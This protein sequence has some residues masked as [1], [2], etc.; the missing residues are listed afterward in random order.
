ME[1]SGALSKITEVLTTSL[2]EG[3]TSLF[4]PE[5]WFG[6]YFVGFLLGIVLSKGSM[7]RYETVSGMFRFF[8]MTFMRV[9]M[10]LFLFGMPMVFLAAN[11]G[12]IVE[13][14][15]PYFKPIALSLG[16]F[17]FGSSMAIGGYCPG[18]GL[19]SLGRGALDVLVW[20]VGLVVGNIFF[21]EVIYGS[22]FHKL[23]E[24]VSL[25]NPTWSKIFGI[26][27]ITSWLEIP[28]ILGFIMM[29]L[30][31]LILMGLF[32]AMNKWFDKTFAWILFRGKSGSNKESKPKKA[33]S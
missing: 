19:A 2:Q 6:G 31:M 7:D 16:A 24:Y 15:P 26:G 21:A 30:V 9:G 8:N 28:F 10:W 23:I 17:L 4:G 33:S 12:L 5:S 20:G 32:D 11:L 25:S 13:S 14:P 27:Y 22:T 3:T 29:F 18:V 1:I